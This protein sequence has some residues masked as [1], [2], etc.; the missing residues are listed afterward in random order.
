MVAARATSAGV[1]H[2]VFC[3]DRFFLQHAAVAAVSM[4]EHSP[5]GRFCVHYVTCD[6]DLDAEAKLAATLAQYPNVALQFHRVDE[7]KIASAFADRHVTEAAYLRFLAPE[8]LAAGDRPDR[9]SR[10]RSCR[11]RRYSRARLDRS[12]RA[13]PSAPRPMPTGPKA[14]RTSAFWRS[15]SDPGMPMSFPECWS[16]TCRAGASRVSAGA[17]STASTSWGRNWRTTTRTPSTSRSGT[18][19]T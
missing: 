4:L 8:I 14:R 10:L 1:V 19:S 5:G 9:L 11:G 12:R 7:S 3:A 17:S 13:W 6:E 18:R 16:W 15:G 2:V